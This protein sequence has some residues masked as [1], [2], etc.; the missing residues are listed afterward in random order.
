LFFSLIA[1]AVL[2]P[3]SIRASGPASQK[4]PRPS[5]EEPAEG[6]PS[7]DE[8]TE[9]VQQQLAK[10]RDYKFGDLLTARMVEPIFGKLEKLNWKVADRKEIVKSILP[11]NDSMARQLSTRSG[12]KFMRQVSD[13]PNGYDRLDRLRR[14]PYGERRIA[15]LI[16]GPDGYKLIEYM[17][18]TPNGKNLGRQL[19]QDP[20][21][22]GFNK[23]TGR[24][25]TELEFLERLKH[26]Y[27]REAVQRLSK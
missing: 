2:S 23:P 14:M 25:Y 15:E 20:N 9:V 8:V 6:F 10:N 4:K 12:K 16:R 18:T 3:S 27:D 21:G 7:F 5:D 13:L 24:I 26:T 1:G 19:S 17:T 22:R 11:D